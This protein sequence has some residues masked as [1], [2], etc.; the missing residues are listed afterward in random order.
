[1]QERVWSARVSLRAGQWNNKWRSL[2]GR[3]I[4]H[5]EKDACD[6]FTSSEDRPRFFT[7]SVT[8]ENQYGTNKRSVSASR[9]RW[10]VRYA[11]TSLSMGDGRRE[12]ERLAGDKG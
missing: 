5:C 12:N 1:M 8:G 2:E 3:R 11:T 7:I 9:K 10:A 6:V 4:V